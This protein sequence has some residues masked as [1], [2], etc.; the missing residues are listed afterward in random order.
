MSKPVITVDNLGKA[1]LL[2]RRIEKNATLRDQL[3]GF[4]RGVGVALAMFFVGLTVFRVTE[5]KF[6]DTI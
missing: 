4:F 6:A 1:Y 2:G 5:P 3:T